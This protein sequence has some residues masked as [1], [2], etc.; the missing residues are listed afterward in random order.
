MLHQVG[1]SFELIYLSPPK[2]GFY[3]LMCE[4]YCTGLETTEYNIIRR[5]R[6]TRW[7]PKATN[8]YTEYVILIVFHCNN[9]N[10]IAPR[11]YAIRTVPVLVKG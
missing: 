5:M 4:K 3:N 7:I 10:A 6:I 8:T 9:G 2:R 11:F 1:V